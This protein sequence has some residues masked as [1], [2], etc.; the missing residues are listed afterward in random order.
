MAQVRKMP[1]NIDAE[2]AIL[3]SVFIDNELIVKLND[4]LTTN[5]FYKK[6]H[7]IIFNAIKKLYD[8]NISLDITTIS[9]E[10]DRSNELNEVGGIEYLGEIIDSVAS[11]SNIDYYIDIIKEKATRRFLIDTAN[12]IATSAYDTEGSLNDLLDSASKEMTEVVNNRKTSDF[13]PI[14]EAIRK[15]Q[16]ILENLAQ[17]KSE[18][19]GIPSGFNDLDRL[20][21]GFHE[22]E[23]II[24]AAR[25]GVGKTAFSLN[26]ATNVALTTKRPVAIFNMEMSVEQLLMRMISSVGGV[27]SKKLRTGRLEHNDWKRVN[28]A[29]SQLG[30]TKLFIEDVSG[31]TISEIKAKCRKLKN[32]EKDLGL[33]I[34]D[35]LQLIQGTS[36]Y[37]G[38]RVQEVTEI[39]RG[40]KTMAMELKVPVIALAQLSRSVETR[41]NKKPTLS[42]L[43]ESGSIEQDADI[44]G[45][46][47]REDY[48][49]NTN[50]VN[51]PTEFI[52]AKHRAGTTGKIDLLFEKNLSNFV[53]LKVTDEGEKI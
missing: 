14:S 29:L 35:Y 8:K 25:P 13:I 31:L 9:D 6:A 15:T 18:L 24:I 7:Q 36:K 28:E 46:L 19:T 53:P 3:G 4:E 12:N 33:V 34:I 11:V 21:T 1:Q 22:N 43:R 51:A 17:N 37:A 47:Y 16:D 42:D 48:Y 23:L 27:D 49:K 44:V 52:I 30:D 5:M 45:F 41:E 40:L 32:T 20:T 38:N 2:M 10:L 50:E 26:I 39:S